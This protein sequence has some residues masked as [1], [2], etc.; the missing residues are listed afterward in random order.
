[1]K[2]GDEVYVHG[3]V[4]E[5]RNDVVI[6]R[7]DGGYFG[8]VEDEII[9][10]TAKFHKDYIEPKVVIEPTD[11]PRS[12]CPVSIVFSC[13]ECH[14]E[15]C[16]YKTENSSEKP[17]NCDTCR[18]KGFEGCE[19]PCLGCGCCGLYEPKDEPQKDECAKEY[20]ELGLRKLKE[21]RKDEPQTEP[22]E[23]FRV[24]LEYHTDTTHF[25]K[26]K[27]ESVTTNKIED[28]PQTD[29]GDFADRLAYER[30]IKH[31]WE[32]AQKVFD[33]TVTFYE[34]EDVAK[35]IAKDEPQ[36]DCDHKCIQTEV[37]CERTDCAW[38]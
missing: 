6:I 21:L 15:K 24:G 12:V 4:D 29:C 13:D 37:G 16:D 18:N 14:R 31:A 25:G 23:Q 33:S 17:N 27:G 36:T 9:C 2:I 26:T 38:K 11:E 3:Y 30:G 8:T 10:F 32:V 34:A 20:E 28:E 7:N 19:Q 22:L 1:M 35:Q 5:I